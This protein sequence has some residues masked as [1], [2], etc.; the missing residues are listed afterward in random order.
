MRHPYRKA[1]HGCDTSRSISEITVSSNQRCHLPE[2]DFAPI[3][4]RAVCFP[5]ILPREDINNAIVVADGKRDKRAE[6]DHFDP[7][8]FPGTTGRCS[9]PALP[10][11]DAGFPGASFP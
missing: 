2:T 5:V 10:P 6:F 8:R 9:R 7:V 3:Q 4:N 1:N 11:C